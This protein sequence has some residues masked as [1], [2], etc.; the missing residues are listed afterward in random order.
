MERSARRT[1]RWHRGRGKPS[2][3]SELSCSIVH[4]RW[5]KTVSYSRRRALMLRTGGR[6]GRGRDD[7]DPPRRTRAA[8]V[9]KC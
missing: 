3:N 7:G 6:P 9:E 2:L 4:R 8:M 5:W 1:A